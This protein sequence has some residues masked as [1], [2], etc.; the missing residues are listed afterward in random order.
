M[1]DAFDPLM[2]VNSYGAFGSVGRERHELIFEGTRDAVV[3]EESEWL[4]YEFP[5]KPGDVERR[6][7]V[8]SPL[9]PRLDWQVWFAAMGSVDDAPWTLHLVWKLL[10]A[11]PGTRRL[12]AHDPF[13][14]EPP[15]HVRVE[16]YRYRFAPLGSDAWWTREH[17]GAWLTPLSAE[18]PRLIEDLKLL[19]V[20]PR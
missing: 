9:Q 15:R 11:D 5:C 14:D 6:P 1:N 7:C 3:T 12:L 20:V 18:D 4:A 17:E 8:L 19:G 13:G 10:H 2:L 16:R